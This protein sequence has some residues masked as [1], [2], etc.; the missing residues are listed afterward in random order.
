MFIELDRIKWVIIL[1]YLA[2]YIHYI[3]DDV[4]FLGIYNGTNI[5]L[6]SKSKNIE[7]QNDLDKDLYIWRSI[8]KHSEEVF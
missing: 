1:L 4:D 5:S 6:E 7:W 2:C 3:H 8:Y